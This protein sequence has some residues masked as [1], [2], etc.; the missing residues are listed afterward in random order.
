M[1]SKEQPHKVKELFIF[2]LEYAHNMLTY[3]KI[4]LYTPFD[5]QISSLY[6]RV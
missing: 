1:F 2:D 6:I 5:Q 3:N 4:P